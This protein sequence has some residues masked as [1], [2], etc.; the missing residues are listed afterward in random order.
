MK[1]CILEQ[2][3][4]NL[5][6][7][8][9]LQANTYLP[10]WDGRPPQDSCTSNKAQQQATAK[11]GRATVLPELLVNEYGHVKNICLLLCVQKLALSNPIT[12]IQAEKVPHVSFHCPC[13]QRHFF[14]VC[15]CCSSSAQQGHHL[16]SK[17]IRYHCRNCT[18]NKQT[19]M[20]KY[21][22]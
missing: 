3:V 22:K 4:C 10:R 21:I 15:R 17:L 20:I 12:Y 2:F 13:S 19:T 1:Y 5:P 16:C 14:W 7:R 18:I 6:L 8:V 9:Y 11:G